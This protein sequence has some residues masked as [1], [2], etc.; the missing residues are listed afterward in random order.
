[1]NTQKTELFIYGLIAV[2]VLI[3]LYSLMKKFGL[4][5]SKAQREATQAKQETRIEKQQIKEL[6]SDVDWFKPGMWQTI[7]A[8]RL[9]TTAYARSLAEKIHN[10][11]GLL[12]DK[13]TQ[14]F[15]V[16]R[17]LKDRA[18]VSQI[19]F[20]YLAKY[21]KDLLGELLDRLNKSEL[22]TIYN[23]INAI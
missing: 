9:Y 18:N 2:V 3:L 23:I 15:G 8:Q 12:I 6:L 11:F 22:Q 1:M 19:A 10:S 14:I 7:P 20:S 21:N 4:I 16:F 13:E 17:S 5:K